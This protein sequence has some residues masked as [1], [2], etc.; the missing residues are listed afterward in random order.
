MIDNFQ[1]NSLAEAISELASVQLYY[2]KSEELFDHETEPKQEFINTRNA[3][4]IHLEFA[5]RAINKFK[6]GLV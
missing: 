3:M 5:E 1:I 2:N 4:W 6:N